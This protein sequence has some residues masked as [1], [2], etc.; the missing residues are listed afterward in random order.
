[1]S[2]TEHWFPGTLWELSEEECLD[3]LRGRSVGRV[4][5]N[6]ADGPVVLPVNYVL[7]N[8]TV[9]FRTAPQNTV[10]RHILSGPAAFEVDE[11]DDYTESGWS[12]LVRGRASFV[13]FDELPESG[14]RPE[15]WVEGTRSLYVRITPQTV[16]GR[17][18]LSQ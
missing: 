18:V 7:D 1:M 8:G 2:T 9:L 11:T 15:P 3:L 12:V 4:A 6:D 13:H 16:T 10:A 17:R 14:S 5:F